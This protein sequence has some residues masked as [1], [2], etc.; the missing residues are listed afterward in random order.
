MLHWIYLK[1]TVEATN[2]ATLKN[3]TTSSGYTIDLTSPRVH[4]VRDHPH[5]LHYQSSDDEMY[6]AW[7][8]DDPESG[9]VEY[10]YRV[11]GKGKQYSYFCF[12][13]AKRID[14]K[15]PRQ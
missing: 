15:I 8:F 12:K 14:V 3:E 1:V 10:K 13:C 6:A 4:Y 11:L 7:F 2:G 9:I 5:D